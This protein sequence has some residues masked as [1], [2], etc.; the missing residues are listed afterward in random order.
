M[1]QVNEIIELFENCKKFDPTK[2]PA[3]PVPKKVEKVE[4]MEV[5]DGQEENPEAK[6][7]EGDAVVEE[8]VEEWNDDLD[9][10]LSRIKAEKA[11]K[12]L[13]TLSMGELKGLSKEEK[14]KLLEEKRAKFRKQKEK[15]EIQEK[16]DK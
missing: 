6:S 10:L 7:N 5:E 16:L 4:A 3:K 8:E 12:G 9:D 2:E 13:D 11:A 15:N 14:I 1:N